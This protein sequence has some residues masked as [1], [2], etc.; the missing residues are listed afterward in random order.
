MV[1]KLKDIKIKVLFKNNNQTCIKTKNKNER[2]YIKCFSI[3]YNTNNNQFINSLK[4]HRNFT[5]TKPISLNLTET[6]YIKYNPD[7]N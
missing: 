5:P 1:I 2:N 7:H 6:N 3:Q 4:K